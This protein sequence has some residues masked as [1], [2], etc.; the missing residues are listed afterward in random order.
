MSY[1]P[2]RSIPSALYPKSYLKILPLME[3][4]QRVD[5]ATKNAGY[6]SRRTIKDL[7][8]PKPDEPIPNPVVNRAKNQAI[9]L[10][11]AVIKRHGAM[12]SIHINWVE[13]SAGTL[14]IEKNR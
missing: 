14:R 7:K 12:R 9:K 4:G 5:A 10:I 8:T 13:I 11:N 2:Y 1:C 3:S 6:C